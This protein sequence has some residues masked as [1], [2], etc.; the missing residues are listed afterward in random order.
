MP[1]ADWKKCAVWTALPTVQ[2]SASH[3]ETGNGSI[4]SSCSTRP[5]SCSSWRRSR[6]ASRSSSL[7]IWSRLIVPP[8]VRGAEASAHPH[9]A[10]RNRHAHF[11]ME[12][13]FGL[14]LRSFCCADCS[15]VDSLDVALLTALRDHP[16]AGDLELSRLLGVARGTVTARLQRLEQAGVVTGHGPDVD[17]A[18]AGYGVQEFVT[19]EIA[20]GALD[21]VRHDLE[22][23]PG[24]LEEHATTGQG[25]VLCRVAA[26]SHGA[27][28]QVRVDLGRS[29]NVVRSTSV[30]ALSVLVP[31]RTLPLLSA[32]AAPGA[33]RSSLSR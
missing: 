27:L 10:L 13:W 4:E 14:A 28:Q 31:F 22:A 26:R 20:Q 19:L 24:V 18:A 21:A 6:P 32:E 5:T 2:T 1:K 17:V 25:D 29:P 30:I 12:C 11:W 7:R 15:A 9:Q 23:I 8:R 3:P 16:R 33:G